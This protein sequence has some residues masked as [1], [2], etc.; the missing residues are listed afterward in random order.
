MGK[1]VA[2]LNEW[3]RKRES[4]GRTRVDG[5]EQE[6]RVVMVELAAVAEI[7]ISCVLRFLDWADQYRTEF[8]HPDDLFSNFGEALWC[9]RAVAQLQQLSEAELPNVARE[10]YSTTWRGARARRDSTQS[11]SLEYRDLLVKECWLVM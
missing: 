11:G 3:P 2:E 1:C 5:E 6:W 9:Y 4:D 8:Q 10:R 7:E